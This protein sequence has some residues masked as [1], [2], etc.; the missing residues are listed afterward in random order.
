[1]WGAP[2]PKPRSSGPRILKKCAASRRSS[3]PT[4]H[5]ARTPL[6]AG[7][8]SSRVCFTGEP[9]R[10]LPS[11]T[12]A[13]PRQPLNTIEVLAELAAVLDRFR[14]GRPLK[15][16]FGANP[17]R[18]STEAQCIEVLIGSGSGD[19]RNCHCDARE[20]SAEGLDDSCQG[21]WD[22]TATSASSSRAPQNLDEVK[23]ENFSNDDNDD[24]LQKQT[25]AAVEH[26]GPAEPQGRGGKGAKAQ[27]GEAYTDWVASFMMMAQISFAVVHDAPRQIRAGVVHVLCIDFLF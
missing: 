4:L 24:N 2:T 9:F 1:M 19:P 6:G 20:E 12:D 10:A 21:V 8:G 25:R 26:A 17:G 7:A 16:K 27:D 3:G 5:E 23:S 11:R 13:P 18:V 22:P 14:S 15:E